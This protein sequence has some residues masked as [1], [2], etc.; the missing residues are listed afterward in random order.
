MKKIINFPPLNW[1]Y[2]RWCISFLVSISGNFISLTSKYFLKMALSYRSHRKTCLQ[3]LTLSLETYHN[4]SNLCAEVLVWKRFSPP[5]RSES[6]KSNCFAVS[7]FSWWRCQLRTLM[8]LNW[9]GLAAVTLASSPEVRTS[10]FLSSLQQ[11]R[12]RF[13]FDGLKRRLC[14]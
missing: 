14:N 11:F 13:R 6:R 1:H 3:N 2:A 12:K 5:V 8:H 9:V 4:P 10:G 7:S